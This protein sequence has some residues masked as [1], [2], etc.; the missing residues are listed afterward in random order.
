MTAV[1]ALPARRADA[2]ALTLA[3]R[4]YRKSRLGVL[5]GWV[6]MVLYLLALLSP[7]LSPYDN[8]AQHQGHESQ[9]PSRLHL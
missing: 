2:S 8:T 3:W 4:R 5:G 7:F 1:P 6:L 9:P